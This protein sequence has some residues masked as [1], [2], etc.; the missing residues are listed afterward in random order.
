M[1]V[2]VTAERQIEENL[3]VSESCFRQMA[4]HISDVF[5]LQN[6]DSSQ[7]Y[8]VSPAYEKIWGRT[9]ESLCANPATWVASIHPDDG[10]HVVTELSKGR[11]TEFDYEYRIVRPDGEVRCVHIRGFPIL[12]DSGNVYRTAGVVSNVT[13]R[14][15]AEL[16]LRES[17]RRF[18]DLLRN[19]ELASVMLD[20]DARITY[21]NEYLL[22][23]TG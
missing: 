9:C 17:E 23:L 6:L 1:H 7:V 18:G 13:Q 21:C 3:R 22:R 10:V 8:Y 19:I 12:D 16:D 2:D 5:F 20:R 11:Q 4:E 15:K 14:N